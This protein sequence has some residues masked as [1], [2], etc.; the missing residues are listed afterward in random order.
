MWSL[1]LLSH[2]AVFAVFRRIL[3]LI[4]SG[5]LLILLILWNC[6]LILLSS[7]IL[8]TRQLFLRISIPSQFL[9][10]LQQRLARPHSQKLSIK[11][12]QLMIT[13]PFNIKF[14]FSFSLI[15]IICDLICGCF[16]FRMRWTV[17]MHGTAYHYV[18]LI[19]QV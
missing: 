3:S 14:N 10:Q 8:Y 6:L 19:G 18:G 4:I 5:W 16:T 12:I 15:K 13:W 17:F 9:H 1:S 11:Q 7:L 2:W